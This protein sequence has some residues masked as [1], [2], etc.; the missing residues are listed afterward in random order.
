MSNHLSL[1][2]K[3]TLKPSCFNLFQSKFNSLQTDK[4]DVLLIQLIQSG[5]LT[6]CGMNKLLEKK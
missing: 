1:V 6:D 2:K 3:F 5:F 4:N